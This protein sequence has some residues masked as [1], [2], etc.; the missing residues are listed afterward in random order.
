MFDAYGVDAA[1]KKLPFFGEKD[2]DDFTGRH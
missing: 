1:F 2:D